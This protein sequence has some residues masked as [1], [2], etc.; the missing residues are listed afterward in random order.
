MKLP[1][2][3]SLK[4]TDYP[5]DYQPLIETMSVS[6]NNGIQVLYDALSKRTTLRENIAGTIKEV[7]VEVNALGIPKDTLIIKTDL[8]TKV[9]GC[10]VLYAL[11]KTS[12]SSYVQ[13]T[14][15]PFISFDAIQN[16]IKIN[17]IAGL[18]ANNKYLLRVYIYQQ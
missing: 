8:M 16:G 17:H 13:T 14:G 2:F 1:S 7:E 3:K 12:A 18:I 5:D 15:G 11:N 10:Q 9:E 6:L 4:K